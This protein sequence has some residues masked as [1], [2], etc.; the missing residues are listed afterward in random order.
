VQHWVHGQMSLADQPTSGVGPTRADRAPQGGGQR[1]RRCAALAR[2]S[3][4]WTAVCRGGQAP[5][6]PDHAQGPSAAGQPMAKVRFTQSESPDAGLTMIIRWCMGVKR[7]GSWSK[8]DR[9]GDQDQKGRSGKTGHMGST[10]VM[11][12]CEL[13]RRVTACAGNR[14][15]LISRP[16]TRRKW[17]AGPGL[18][19]RDLPPGHPAGRRAGVAQSRPWAACRRPGPGPPASHR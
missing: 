1:Q 13:A 8:G 2:W 11:N 12:E 19:R 10:V 17:R 9:T 14:G 15:L 3:G 4:C 16:V 7:N 6:G 5:Q 18:P